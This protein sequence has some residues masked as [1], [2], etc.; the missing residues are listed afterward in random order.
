MKTIYT[1]RFILRKVTMED[2]DNIYMILRDKLTVK[3][4]NLPPIENK[5]DVEKIV[6]DYLVENKKK[7]KY[8]F[9][10]CEKTTNN[11]IGVFL[12]KLDL[13]DEDCFEFTI[14]LHRKY[15]NKGIY[16]EILPIMTKFAFDEIG[17]GN[18]RGFVMKNNHASSKVLLNNNFK[19]EKIFTVDGLPEE[20]ESYLMTK[21]DYIRCKL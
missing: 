11:L 18:F 15:W 9:A 20:I 5:K 12:I 7:T 2:V 17:T 4:L 13:F 16:S 19:L 1:E 3:Y 6:E 8:P 21:E 10:V 14:Y